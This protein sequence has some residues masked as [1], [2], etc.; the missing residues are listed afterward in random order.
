MPPIA[1]IILTV[2]M[3]IFGIFMWVQRGWK[4]LVLGSVGTMVFFAIPYSKTGGI[5]SNI[6]EPIICGVIILTA[7]HIA[8]KY[9]QSS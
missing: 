3:I 1:P 6:G 8:Q 5:F 7:A 4:W 9:G 2:M